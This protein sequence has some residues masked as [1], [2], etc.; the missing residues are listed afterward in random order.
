MQSE[1]GQGRQDIPRQ[2][3]PYRMGTEIEAVERRIEEGIRRQGR[4][5]VATRAEMAQIGDPVQAE[6]FA[7]WHGWAFVNRLNGENY[8][9]FEACPGQELY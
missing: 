4:Y 1:E 6:A 8:E 9:F 7:L 2:P 5:F 3:I